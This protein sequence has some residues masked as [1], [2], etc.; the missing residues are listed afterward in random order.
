VPDTATPRRLEYVPL[1]ELQPALTNP[2]RHAVAEIAGAIDKFGFVDT[3]IVDERTGLLV[4]GHGR[5]ADLIERKRKGQRPPDGVVVREG[6]GEW[7]VPTQRGW[8]SRSDAEAEAAG[9]ALNRIGE[10]G[11]WDDPELL[12]SLDRLSEVDPALFAVTGFD[13]DFLAK[14][15]DRVGPEDPDFAPLDGEDQPAL[16][17]RNPVT[18]PNCGHTFEPPG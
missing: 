2:K 9:L 13:V 8:A 1:S 4:A 17:H 15:R 3:P 10:R 7:L 11:G 16:D 12:A 18:C 14:L 6:D 5:R